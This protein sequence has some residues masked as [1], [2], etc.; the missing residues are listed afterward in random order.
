MVAAVEEEV[1][2]EV[3][4]STVEEEARHREETI[5]VTGI[6]TDSLTGAG[7]TETGLEIAATGNV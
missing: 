6:E 4:I 5:A 3:T 1:V 2:S 7:A